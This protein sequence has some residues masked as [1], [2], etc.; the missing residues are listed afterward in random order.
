MALRP[1]DLGRTVGISAQQVRNYEE[2]GLLPPAP[3]SASG[4]RQFTERHRE[5][6]LTYR[7]LLAGYGV[8]AARAIMR[9]VHDDD[10]PGAL[11]LVDAAHAD[12]HDQRRQLRETAGAV[13]TLAA[14]APRGGPAGA[15]RGGPGLRVGEVARRLGVRTSALRTWEAY[16]LLAPAREPGTSY[17]SYTADDVRDAQLV[18]LLRQSH[19]G[20]PQVR[21]VLDELRRTGSTAALRAVLAQRA[22]QLTARALAML[23]GSGRLHA[24]VTTG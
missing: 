5:A 23:D 7:A 16:G 22:D 17:R 21:Q 14:G 8:I 19:Y 12:L 4:Y 15:P 20:L 24:Y 13:E 6:L 9:S 3:R 11:A 1:V 18:N 10:V 2:D